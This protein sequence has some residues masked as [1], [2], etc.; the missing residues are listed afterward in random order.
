MIPH[1]VDYV[2]NYIIADE[3]GS[4]IS[5]KFQTAIGHVELHYLRSAIFGL[6]NVKC[7][8]D[9]SVE[10]AVV[11]EGWWKEPFNLGK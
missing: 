4:T 11:A 3:P 1:F 10:D 9:E 2:Q 5:F 8:V 6:G 7:W